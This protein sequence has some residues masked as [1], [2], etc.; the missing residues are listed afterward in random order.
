MNELKKKVAYL[1]GLAEGLDLDKDS[2]EG[3]MFGAVMDVLE[4]VV[5]EMDKMAKQQEELENYM[6]AI[7]EDLGD[8]EQEV[9]G[10]DDDYD[11]EDEDEDE[12]DDDDD[13]EDDDE[14]E[15]DECRCEG[16][17]VEVECPKCHDIVRFDSS[18]LADEDVIEVTCPNCDEVVYVN[19]DED[20]LTME[21]EQD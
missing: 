12:D 2:K 5:N 14:D 11:D 10:D 9:Y 8:L 3:K 21:K 1:Q 16:N 17:Y 7:D 13:Y 18:I 19:D 6:D 4:E 15:D 20:R